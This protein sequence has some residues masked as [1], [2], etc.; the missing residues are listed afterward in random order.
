MQPF[1]QANYLHFGGLFSG[2]QKYRVGFLASIFV[3]T[4]LLKACNTGS[5]NTSDGEK[6]TIDVF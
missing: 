2:T 1:S 3:A 4:S 6:D 5:S